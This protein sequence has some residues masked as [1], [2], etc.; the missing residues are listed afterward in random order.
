[1]LTLTSVQICAD[2]KSDDSTAIKHEGCRSQI[3]A[4]HNAR[5]RSEL[6]V[7]IGIA[8]LEG[9]VPK[10]VGPTLCTLGITVMV[11]QISVKVR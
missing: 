4:K 2:G 1:M 10:V 9:G 8:L 7:M 3:L 5:F 11:R 6:I